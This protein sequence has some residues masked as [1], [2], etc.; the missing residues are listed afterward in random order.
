M[1][2]EFVRQFEDRRPAGIFVQPARECEFFVSKEDRLL[3]FRMTDFERF[4]EIPRE[5]PFNASWFS[6]SVNNV[7]E[8]AQFDTAPLV[9]QARNLTTIRP[10][11]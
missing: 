10:F 3:L 1:A 8:G 11:A 2:S 4:A 5:F 9:T 6:M 7:V